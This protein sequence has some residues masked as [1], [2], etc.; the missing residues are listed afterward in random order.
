M[1]IAITGALGH[2]G[3]ALIRTIQ[4]GQFEEVRL[5][6]N[7]S[8]QR[9]CSLFD[10]PRGIGF[11]F[12]EADVVT[13]ELEPLL[14][15][16]G[17]VVHL[18]ALTD[19]ATSFGRAAEV[20]RVNFQ[21]TERVAA[22][23]RAVGARPVFASSTSV[24]GQNEGIV[25]EASPVVP[26]S[27]YAESKTRGEEMLRAGGHDACILRFG[28]IFG[29]SPGMR[30]HT[31]VNRFCWQA[32]TGQPITVWR[33]ALDQGRPYL[34]ILDACRAIWFAVE[35][36]LF[37]GE[38]YNVVTENATVGQIVEIIRRHAPRLETVFVDSPIMNQ[39][40]YVV[41]REKIERAGMTFT[42]SLVEGV[43]ETMARL[44]RVGGREMVA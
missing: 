17:A 28:T 30:F 20:E 16:C 21:G 34:D 14:D 37:G 29:I 12:T 31:A 25:T 6:D 4:P 9:L 35:R 27:P 36:G 15:G 10:L 23:C 19:A 38:T 11:Q 13:S 18:A 8:T 1:K 2:I 42:G 41:S 32:S 7:L 44:A 5:I 26:Q 43:A 24:Y 33:T 3:S 39:L 22:A 40:S